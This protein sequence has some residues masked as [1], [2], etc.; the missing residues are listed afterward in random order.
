MTGS[1]QEKR[2]Q[3]Y[4]VLSFKDER[5]KWKTKWVGTKLEVK[6]N[7]KRAEKFLSGLISKHENEDFYKSKEILFVDY[8][9]KWLE[10]KK[11]KVELKTWDGYRY[12]LESHTI[13]YFEPLKLKIGEVKPKHI[14][15]YYD[16][17]SKSG[18]LDGKAGGMSTRAIKLQSIPMNQAFNDAVVKEIIVKNPMEHV[19]I[20]K[21]LGEKEKVGKFLEVSQIG[22]MLKL[23]ENH[24]LRPV[25]YIALYYGL[26][27]S[28]VLG[29]KW[30]AVDFENNVLE[31][32]HTVVDVAGVPI[33]KDKTKN[34]SSRRK[35]V[36]LPEIK[37]ML[38][39]LKNKQNENK[40]LF[41]NEY[42]ESDYIFTWADGRLFRPDFL[43]KGF[44][45]VLEKNNFPIM[46][47]HDL[48]H[49]CATMLHDKGWELGD[50]KQWL[51]HSNVST[52]ADIYTHISNM[53]MKDLAKDLEGTFNFKVG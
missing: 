45:K 47:F 4:C 48:R 26:R 41:G 36:I 24:E 51:G 1:L 14:I 6:G 42:N 18:R 3:Y 30:N 15:E 2:G 35:Y 11:D 31:I 39:D 8:L 43:T 50:A 32:K 27:R 53:R 23:F 33:A 12:T 25:I 10:N 9:K 5:G 38:I 40:K 19:P 28:E 16:H 13:P 22:K 34:T 7:K 44:K 17:K 29:L 46:R 20:P 21:Q 37:D 49:S 52:T